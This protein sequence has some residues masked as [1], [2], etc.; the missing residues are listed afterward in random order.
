LITENTKH[1][2]IIPGVKKVT[3][4]PDELKKKM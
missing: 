1:F 3:I 2:D 4:T